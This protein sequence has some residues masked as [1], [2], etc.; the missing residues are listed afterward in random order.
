MDPITA[1]NLEFAR[2][3]Q[4][5]WSR[6]AGDGRSEHTT[7]APRVSAIDRLRPPG[8]ASLTALGIWLLKLPA[9]P[10]RAEHES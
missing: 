7:A 9:R 4:A 3:A 2:L 8:G 5:D 6:A 10:L 1:I